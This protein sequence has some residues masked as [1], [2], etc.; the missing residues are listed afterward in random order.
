MTMIHSISL[1][2]PLLAARSL[3]DN[4]VVALGTWL[5]RTLALGE[6]TPY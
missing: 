3:T 6:P 2:V 5:A 1:V 4:H